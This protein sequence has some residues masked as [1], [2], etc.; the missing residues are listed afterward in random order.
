MAGDLTQNGKDGRAENNGALGRNDYREFAL[1]HTRRIFDRLRLTGVPTV[2]FGVGTA[3]GAAS[4][5]FRGP[6]SAVLDQAFSRTWALAGDPLPPDEI[7]DPS[8]CRPVGDVSVRVVEGVPAKS[9]IYRL[10]QFLALAVEQRRRD[11]G[12]AQATVQSLRG[13]LSL[14]QRSVEMLE[15]LATR[16]II[17]ETELL[18]ARR[19]LVDIQG[20]LAAAQEAVSRASAGIRE[21]QAQVGTAQQ[22]FRQEAL[23]ERSQITTRIA[24][25]EQTARGAAGRMPP[26]GF[27]SPGHAMAGRPGHVAR[28]PEAAGGRRSYR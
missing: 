26:I 4:A 22:E 2:H 5:E 11:L 13:S 14:A 25:N 10:S 7:P 16:N 28:G 27:P 6:V 21:A 15:P 8:C 20:R 24:V 17:P 23:N 19:E 3:A 18:Q 1:P 12:E 9:R